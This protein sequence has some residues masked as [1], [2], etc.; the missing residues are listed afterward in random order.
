VGHGGRDFPDRGEAFG[1]EELVLGASQLFVDLLEIG[2]PA[3]QFPVLVRDRPGGAP[4]EGILGEEE[5]GATGKGNDPDDDPAV[6][7][8]GLEEDGKF[9]E[10]EDGKDL[11]RVGIHNRDVDGREFLELAQLEGV[12]WRGA[13]LFEGNDDGSIEGLPDLRVVLEVQSD[14]P[15]LVGPDD[16]PARI[17]DLDAHRLRKVQK[18]LGGSLSEKA[19][20]RTSSS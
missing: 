15:G 10:L 8:R 17:V 20:S 18:T 4:D 6:A 9:V 19:G 13:D 2:R 5:K 3:L 16:R 14:D 1:F 7:D 12:L 11:V